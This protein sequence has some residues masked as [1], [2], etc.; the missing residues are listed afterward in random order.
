MS[1]S[2][3]GHLHDVDANLTAIESDLE[4]YRRKRLEPRVLHL[5]RRGLVPLTT[6]FR[7]SARVRPVVSATEAKGHGEH[8]LDE[9]VASL[10]SRLDAFVRDVATAFAPL[11]GHHIAIDDIRRERG[12]YDPFFVIPKRSFEGTAEERVQKLQVAFADSETL[13]RVFAEALVDTGLVSRE[14]LE[15]RHREFGEAGYWNGARIV[16]RAWV[17]PDFKERLL[18][19]GRRAIRELDIP[20]GKVGILGVAE[21]TPEVHNVV[22]CTLCSCY[23]SDLLGQPPWWYRSDDYRRDV[24]LDPR[25]LLSE[26]FG[27]DVSPDVQVRVYDSTSDVRWMVVP[28]RPEGTEDWTEEQLARLV[29]AE[30][31]IGTGRALTPEE[32]GPTTGG[33]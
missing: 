8:D 29:T 23:P 11:D 20:P 13:V 32:V 24:V 30:S 15:T 18:T 22:V 3:P 25:R 17:D 16:A 21:N 7:A 12:N 6:L 1:E 28:Q 27:V 2:G 14:M 31:L 19:Q 4:Y 10:Q 9:A 26:Q 33:R 5:A